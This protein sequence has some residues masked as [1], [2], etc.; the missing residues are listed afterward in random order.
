[1][2]YE[3]PIYRPPSEADSLLI[4]ATIG[5]PHNRCTFCMVYKDGPSYRVRPVDDIKEDMVE[6]K[7]IY[8]PHVRTM[9]LPAGNTIAMKTEDLAEVCS[10]AKMTF[11]TIDRI[12]VYGSSQF[13]HKKG[14]IQ[15]ERL[16]KAGLGRIHVGIESGDDVVL[17]R[18]RKGTH[19]RQQ[20]EAGR[21]VMAAGIELSLYVILGIGGRE[22]TREHAEETARVIN[23]IAPDFLRLRTFVPKTNTPLL[24]DVQAGR[25]EMLTPHGVLEETK[26]LLE[27]LTIA[28]TLTSDH[29]TNYINLYGSLP[30]DK[31]RLLDQITQAS[32]WD[33][34]CFRPFF[35]GTQ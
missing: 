10:F 9:F 6:A 21:W 5:C 15:L 29:Y 22:R 17:R 16:A 7:K 25:F 13:I 30:E 2:R 14:P 1:M 28:T 27:G 8:G 4:Q 20:I 32:E 34:S 12:T 23:E 19:A 11:P 18:I 31:P 26:A 3:G 33:E 35:V 24:E